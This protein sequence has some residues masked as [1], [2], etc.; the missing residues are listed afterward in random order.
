[1]HFCNPLNSKTLRK[2][3]L[4]VLVSF[5]TSIIGPELAFAR[6]FSIE[7]TLRPGTTRKTKQTVKGFLNRVD[8]EENQDQNQRNASNIRLTELPKTTTFPLPFS[9]SEQLLSLAARFSEGPQKITLSTEH[10]TISADRANDATT[11]YLKSAARGSLPR[12]LAVPTVLGQLFPSSSIK[13]ESHLGRT[14]DGFIADCQAFQGELIPAFKQFEKEGKWIWLDGGGIGFAQNQLVNSRLC[15]NMIPVLVDP[16]DWK[17]AD[18][19]DK[20]DDIVMQAGMHG[21]RNPWSKDN[22]HYVQGLL[23]PNFR[24]TASEETPLRFISLIAV[25][26]FNKD[27][28]GTLVNLYNQ[29]S[30]GGYIVANLP[31][32]KDYRQN[33]ELVELY[34]LWQKAFTALKKQGIGK[35]AVTDWSQKEFSYQ[36]KDPAPVL[37]LGM[38]LKKAKENPILIDMNLTAREP[39]FITQV[40]ERK[41][42]LRLTLYDG[43]LDE[44][45][46][47]RPAAR[48]SEGS[49]PWEVSLGEIE[50]G[51]KI[52]RQTGEDTGIVHFDLTVQYKPDEHFPFKAILKTAY[53][54]G[55]S[56]ERAPCGGNTIIEALE[57]VFY[58]HRTNF[59]GGAS[60]SLA[61]RVA[62][63]IQEIRKTQKQS[64]FSES[65]WTTDLKYLKEIYEEDT[66]LQQRIRDKYI[67][68]SADKLLKRIKALGIKK[69]PTAPAGKFRL[70]APRDNIRAFDAEFKGRFMFVKYGQREFI[71]EI[72]ELSAAGQGLDATN[73]QAPFLK[74]QVVSKT[75][76][77]ADA[78]YLP[79]TKRKLENCFLINPPYLANE[80]ILVFGGFGDTRAIERHLAEQ[81]FDVEVTGHVDQVW[82]KFDSATRDG[83][84]ITTIITPRS[85]HAGNVAFDEAEKK[86]RERG[87]EI[88]SIFI[89]PGD[90]AKDQLWHIEQALS[91]SHFAEARLSAEGQRIRQR[92]LTLAPDEK[93]SHLNKLRSDNQRLVV[94]RRLLAEG[95]P[96]SMGNLGR[97]LD[98]ITSERVRR[99]E[100]AAIRWL[101]AFLNASGPN[102]IYNLWPEL[103]DQEAGRIHMMVERMERKGLS[104]R[105]MTDFRS[106]TREDVLTCYRFGEGTTL[107]KLEKLLK[108]RGIVIGSDNR[109]LDALVEKVEDGYQL[110]VRRMINALG[111]ETLEDLEEVSERDILRAHGAKRETLNALKSALAEMNIEIGSKLHSLRQER[112]SKAHFAEAPGISVAVKDVGLIQMHADGK[113]FTVLKPAHSLATS[114]VEAGDTYILSWEGNRITPGGPERLMPL[115]WLHVLREKRGGLIPGDPT[116]NIPV[117]CPR[118]EAIKE[119]TGAP[120]HFAETK[121]VLI[122]ED[123]RGVTGLME[124]IVTGADAGI[125][126]HKA[127]DAKTAIELLESGEVA[128]VISD[129]VLKGHGNGIDVVRHATKREIPSLVVGGIANA[130]ERQEF[131]EAGASQVF[132][133]PGFDIMELKIAILDG[134]SMGDKSIGLRINTIERELQT[135]ETSLLIRQGKLQPIVQKWIGGIQKAELGNVN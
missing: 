46:A 102:S 17:E 87:Y 45:F 129:C 10:F 38:V 4:L 103:T 107:K 134:L 86:A 29:L 34:E 81:G 27:P 50:P 58:I 71:A 60:K 106:V 41:M 23:S 72:I 76:Q 36:G 12:P 122:V 105:D 119:A 55:S 85:T 16:I 54:D 2:I 79:M 3:S 131:L 108:D 83:K 49:E 121:G 44:P 114:G 43:D 73:T 13:S 31:I 70:T 118:G 135:V 116:R 35:L 117:A 113:R 111:I 84:R 123:Y 15:P 61:S 128:L 101:T 1:M 75:R 30:P 6:A 39:K 25:L 95:T 68:V 74:V 33:Q 48:F 22:L 120:V 99:I 9:P 66:A 64:R 21:I 98:G 47:F 112:D 96:E 32:P 42:Q 40:G 126:I 94:E 52:L 88:R 78:V 92:L 127:E 109:S 67:R 125:T 7:D 133:K 132:K 110:R 20:H 26:G 89:N 124:I 82:R 104:V 11:K 53:G 115:R 57:G 8:E 97:T 51:K 130:N 63:Q 5:I 56:E 69:V 28:L 80:A 14:Y 18:F 59:V 77:D 91:A 62:R 93:T 65:T 100:Q 19:A 90:R 37:M 24:I